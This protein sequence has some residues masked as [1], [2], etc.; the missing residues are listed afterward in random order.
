MFNTVNKM[1]MPSKLKN[2]ILMILLGATWPLIMFVFSITLIMP[3]YRSLLVFNWPILLLYEIIVGHKADVL[4]Y[5]GAT[6][7]FFLV[8]ISLI[9]LPIKKMFKLLYY[10][11][12]V[13]AAFG[14]LLLLGMVC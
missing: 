10:Y 8:L 5:Y 11:S 7:I 2:F 13:Q 3:N 6:F 9:F 1:D 14:A 12:I 4:F